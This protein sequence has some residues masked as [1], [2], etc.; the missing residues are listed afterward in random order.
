MIDLPLARAAMADRLAA[1]GFP[2]EV[3]GAMRA[4][5]RHAFVPRAYWRIA[6]AEIDL[7]LGE[8][9]LPAPAAIARA[10]AAL[11]QQP[12]QRVL[13]IG[14]GSGYQTAVLAALDARVFTVETA[15]GY[16]LSLGALARYGDPSIERSLGGGLDAFAADAPFDAIVANVPVA[17]VPAVLSDQLA[18]GGRMVAPLGVPGAARLVLWRADAAGALRPRDLGPHPAAGP[19]APAAFAVVPGA[20]TEP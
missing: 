11:A 17:A 3:I 8:T 7:R 18:P 12:G 2:P 4:V 5:P 10:A 19:R 6:Y 20:E 16:D 9:W 14:T 15:G 13:E 1:I